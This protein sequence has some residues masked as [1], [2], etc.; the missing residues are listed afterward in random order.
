LSGRYPLK[1]ELDISQALDLRKDNDCE[2]SKSFG[3]HYSGEF[4]VVFQEHAKTLKVP[5][6]RVD[7]DC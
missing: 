4:D 3:L 1:E 7:L 2:Y 5:K 6:P